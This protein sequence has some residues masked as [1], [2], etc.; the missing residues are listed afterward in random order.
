MT[1]YKLETMQRIADEKEKA[2]RISLAYNLILALN[3]PQSKTSSKNTK[4]TGDAADL[5]DD[6]AN[7]QGLVGEFTYEQV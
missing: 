1:G 6:K 4:P 7:P 3:I 5:A 2:R